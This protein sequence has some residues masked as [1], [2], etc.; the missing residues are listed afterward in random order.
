MAY[1]NPWNLPG[2]EADARDAA[3]EAARASGLSVGEWVSQAIHDRATDGGEFRPR[4]QS[5]PARRPGGEGRSPLDDL[6][7]RLERI[8]HG[9]ER[10]ERLAAE[11]VGQAVDLMQRSLHESELRTARALENLERMMAARPAAPA[12]AQQAA[13]QRPKEATALD[14]SLGRLM[15]RL[16]AL[17]RVMAAPAARPAP[18][19]GLSRLEKQIAA[20]ASRLETATAEPARENIQRIEGKLATILDVLRKPQEPPAARTR[21][22]VPGATMPV[23]DLRAAVAEI[24]QRQRHLDR[25]DGAVD[26]AQLSA[27]QQEIA[28]LAQR[29]D[30]AAPGALQDRLREDLHEIGRTLE[31]LAPRHQIA[32]LESG[33]EALAAKIDDLRDQGSRAPDLS[34]AEQVLHDIR[35]SVERLREPESLREIGGAVRALLQKVDAIGQRP[36]PAPAM[37]LEPLQRQIEQLAE[38][39]GRPQ[40]NGLRQLEARLGALDAKFDALLSRPHDDRAVAAVQAAVS[41]LESQFRTADPARLLARVEERIE[42]LARRIDSTAE[43]PAEQGPDPVALITERLDRIQERLDTRAPVVTQ[44]VAADPQPILSLLSG[45]MDRL[46][47]LLSERPAPAAP[48]TSGLER[49]VADLASR[50]DGIG[51]N[52]TDDDGLGALQGEVRRLSQKL[53]TLPHAVPGLADLERKVSAVLA[54]VESTRLEAQRMGDTAARAAAEAVT[55]SLPG[56]AEPVED[57]A[58]QLELARLRDAQERAEQRTQDTLEAVHDTLE[59]IVQ[60]LSSLETPAARPAPAAAPVEA[61]A[62]APQ[63]RDPAPPAALALVPEEPATPREPPRGA[64][65]EPQPAGRGAVHMAL[66]AARQA[67]ASRFSGGQQS[68]APP[69]PPASPHRLGQ[70]EQPSADDAGLFDMPL[71]PGSGRPRAGQ[72]ARAVPTPAVSEPAGDPKAEF[73]ASARRAAQAAAQQSKDALAQPKRA[74]GTAAAVAQRVSDVKSAGL[75]KK[76]VLLLGLAA[77]VVAIGATLQIMG[78]LKSRSNSAETERQRSGAIERPLD[79]PGRQSGLSGPVSPLTTASAPSRSAAGPDEGAP[80]QALP[81]KQGG[82]VSA[83]PPAVPRAPQEQT[84][85]ASQPAAA[86]PADAGLRTEGLVGADRLRLAATEGNL[87]AMTEIGVRFAEGRGAPRDM[88]AA[89]TWLRKAADQGFAP[90]QYRLAGLY[91]EG[92]GIDRDNGRAFELFEQA[93]NAGHARAMHNAGVLLAEGVKGSPDYAGAGEWFRRAAELGTRDSQYNLAILHARGLGVAQDLG[94][95]YHWFAAAARAGDEDAGKKRDEVAAR[96]PGPKLAEARTRFQN[97]KPQPLDPA[98]NDIQTPAG[99]WDAAAAQRPAAPAPA[100]APVRPRAPTG[101]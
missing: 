10:T 55:R 20:L 56:P 101:T 69:A 80:A 51:R 9:Q 34:Q 42:T 46:D 90:A 4:R 38:V 12:A 67:V 5:R 7:R 14:G 53:E 72:P 71:E 11:S 87:S 97:W 17:E 91:R 79:E 86:T 78:A 94:W 83:Q 96:L 88:R 66:E 57:P 30:L 21:P 23:R 26:T 54:E 22:K 74:A 99:G 3:F 52:G 49:M 73:L 95:S 24:A 32:A 61:R 58:L 1:G 50:I 45:R 100:A 63:P 84:G 15:G 92:K 75:K 85:V 28:G 48:D 18:D 8:G 37:S 39:V 59:R 31:T 2:V 35:Q 70:P 98:V 19:A 68:A 43:A 65:V 77:L 29:I 40:D 60:R 13:Q 76:H 82:R 47:T 44:P 62:F 41:G 33:I 36:L 16:D 27:L 93:A 25:G 6:N 89:V 64:P 81:P